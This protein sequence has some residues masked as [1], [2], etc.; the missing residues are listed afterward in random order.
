MKSTTLFAAALLALPLA[1]Q[2][3]PTTPTRQQVRKQDGTGTGNP[4]RLQKR[5]GSCGN[6][7]CTGTGTGTQ[8]RKGRGR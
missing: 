4:S 7:T 6:T 8:A 5:D 2:S 3:T 1:A